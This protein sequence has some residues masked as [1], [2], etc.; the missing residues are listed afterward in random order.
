MKVLSMQ[1]ARKQPEKTFFSQTDKT[2]PL[3]LIQDTASQQG[4][5]PPIFR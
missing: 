2:F 5:K 4:H 1:D 3:H